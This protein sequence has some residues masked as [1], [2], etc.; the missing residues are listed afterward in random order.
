MTV[1]SLPVP[2]RVS[3]AVHVGLLRSPLNVTVASGADVLCIIAN[4]QKTQPRG[5]TRYNAGGGQQAITSGPDGALW[6][7]MGSR[8]GR[9]P[10]EVY[11]VAGPLCTGLDVLARAL[12]RTIR[13]ACSN[14]MTLP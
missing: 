9:M 3:T 1:V 8:V 6:Y 5:V 2:G 11:D 10:E 14:R 4:T 12:R 13:A 7:L